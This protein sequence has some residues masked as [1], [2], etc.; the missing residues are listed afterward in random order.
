MKSTYGDVDV[1]LDCLL[2]KDGPR[3]EVDGDLGEYVEDHGEDGQVHRDP[4]TSE[5]LHHVLWEGSH[6]GFRFGEILFPIWGF[7]VTLLAMKTGMKTKPR[8]WSRMRA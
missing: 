4:S 8:S 7:V 6:L 2:D 1:P 5:P 3:V